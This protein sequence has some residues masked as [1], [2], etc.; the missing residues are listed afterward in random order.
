MVEAYLKAGFISR[1]C[2]PW[3]RDDQFLPMIARRSVHSPLIFMAGDAVPKHQSSNVVHF[4]WRNI[5]QHVSTDAIE[6]PSSLN[7]KSL[8]FFQCSDL[9][10]LDLWCKSR[11]PSSHRTALSATHLNTYTFT[12]HPLL[13][14]DPHHI[15]QINQLN[16]STH[17]AARHLQPL[18]I[19]SALNLTADRFYHMSANRSILRNPARL[20]GFL[21][22]LFFFFFFF[23]TGVYC[24]HVEHSNQTT[25][26]ALH[27]K[28]I[29]GLRMNRVPKTRR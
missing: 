13:C 23:L 22:L 15:D 29:D 19:H 25:Q 16:H 18:F 5:T 28:R 26:Q 24:V 8:N 10:T 6:W 11:L 27:R 3:T 21:F 12:L 2:L 7:T 1:C 9:F 20:P 4:L 14:T 17:H